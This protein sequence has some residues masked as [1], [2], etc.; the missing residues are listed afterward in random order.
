MLRAA[1]K[2]GQVLVL[3]WRLFPDFVKQKIKL[4]GLVR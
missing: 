4:P 3:T 2:E 1:A